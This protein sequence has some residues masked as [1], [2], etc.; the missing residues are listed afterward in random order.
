[1]IIGTEPQIPGVPN[2]EDPESPYFHGKP[3]MV[4]GTVHGLQSQPTAALLG[5]GPAQYPVSVAPWQWV[6]VPGR[7]W[8]MRGSLCQGA[9]LAAESGN[10]KIGAC[11]TTYA[12][13]ESCPRNCPLFAGGGCYGEVD[14]TGMQNLNLNESGH[15]EAEIATQEASNISQIARMTRAERR[16]L[17]LTTG[18]VLHPLR[19]HTVGDCRTHQ[20]ARMVA[21]AC[22]EYL[23]SPDIVAKVNV[24]IGAKPC[25]SYTHAWTTK[26]EDWLGVSILKSCHS[27]RELERADRTGWACAIVV[28]EYPYGKG[29]FKIGD[30][31]VMPCR[32][33]SEHAERQAKG[34]PP[35]PCDEC[36]WCWADEWLRAG[37]RVVAFEAHGAAAI[38]AKGNSFGRVS[39]DVPE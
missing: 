27:V 18:G 16:H 32:N 39:A 9:I 2:P 31:H 26:R 14:H 1:M 33:I 10:A 17:H 5:A 22:M 25:W 19:V 37:K 20:S 4:V 21:S 23:A 38:A 3:G 30:Y 13:Q 12:S 35:V 28:D 6:W 8:R 29:H 36:Q 24:K 15:S 11:A 7:G 34:Q